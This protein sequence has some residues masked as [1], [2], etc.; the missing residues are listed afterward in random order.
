MR[1]RETLRPGV[2]LLPRRPGLPLGTHVA[3]GSLGAIYSRD[4]RLPGGS[5]RPP[6]PQQAPWASF[7]W[8][9]PGSNF[10]VFPPH[11]VFAGRAGRALGTTFTPV[12]FITG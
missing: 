9:A 10:S 6:R 4:A 8:K 3:F 1:A 11:S 12:T 5:W 7:P 2:P